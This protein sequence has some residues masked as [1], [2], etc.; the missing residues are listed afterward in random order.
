MGE[1]SAITSRMLNLEGELDAEKETRS[2]HRIDLA[3]KNA[4]LADMEA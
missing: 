3:N 1:D 2:A 4:K